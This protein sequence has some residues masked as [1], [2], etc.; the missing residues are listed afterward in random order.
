MENGRYFIVR[1]APGRHVFRSEDGRK[2]ETD[3]AGGNTYYFEVSLMKGDGDYSSKFSFWG[4]VESVD[5]E[6]GVK[7]V[8]RLK[9]SSKERIRNAALVVGTYR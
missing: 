7:D 9:P 6:R 5:G 1:V 8:D 2:L 4:H 3:M